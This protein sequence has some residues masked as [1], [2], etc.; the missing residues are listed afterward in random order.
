MVASYGSITELTLFRLYFNGMFHNYSKLHV[1]ITTNLFVTGGCFQ[2]GLPD[3]NL[4]ILNDLNLMSANAVHVWVWIYLV[5]SIF[6]TISSVTLI[7]S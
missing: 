6:W 5:V 4:D 3:V 1:R 7:T 2:A